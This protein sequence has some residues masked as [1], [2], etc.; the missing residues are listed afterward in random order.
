MSKGWK[1]TG[2][3]L[4]ALV[5]L[6]LGG[7]KSFNDNPSGGKTLTVDLTALTT[8]MQGQGAVAGLASSP[9]ATQV[10]ALVIGALAVSSRNTPY[11]PDVAINQTV[12]DNL[13]NEL[14][15][16]VNYFALVKLPVSENFVSFKVPPPAAGKWQ[17]AAVGLSTQPAALGNLGDSEHKNSA[18]YYGFGD[19]FLTYDTVADSPYSLTLSR[20]C[21]V[22]G[23][24]KGC[25]SFAETLTGT[26]VV[27]ASVEIQAI[28]VNGASYQPSA[29]TLPYLAWTDA[30]A[31]AAVTALK[32]ELATIRTQTPSLTSLTVETT[33]SQNPLESAACQAGTYSACETQSYKVNF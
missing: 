23:P 29:L 30:Q 9:T 18:V 26:P 13:E 5:G 1:K 3:A 21:L 14:S 7:C 31:S 19:R 28:K 15:N 6:G 10:K 27:T 25:A 4:A 24:P 20:A 16:S 33:H 2:L 17:I 8:Q 32:T 11:G 12:K 22:S